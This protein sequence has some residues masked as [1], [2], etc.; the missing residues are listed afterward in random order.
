MPDQRLQVFVSS[1]PDELASERAAVRRVIDELRL[2][3]VMSASDSA[4]RVQL[5]DIFVGIYGESYGS[6]GAGKE[7]SQVEDEYVRA[8][9]KT[10]LIY[11]KDQ[12]ARRDARL[13][14]LVRR[15]ESDGRA[16]CKR[17]SDPTELA[18]ELESDLI[19]LL[20]E[21][22]AP[23]QVELPSGT[24]TMLF[25][26]IEGSTRLVRELG[27]RY[28]VVLADHHQVLREAWRTHA[29][30]EI[31]TDGDSF[32][33]VFRR[34]R[35]AVAAAVQAQR[36]LAAHRWPEGADLRVRMGMH[37]G[38]PA[39]GG[40]NYVGLGVH[41]AAR[42]AAAAHGGQVLLS[43][44][45]RYVLEKDELGGV[46]IV[47]LGPQ[48]LKDFEEPQ[49]LYQLGIDGLQA[50]FPALKTLAA[51]GENELP[52]AGQEVELA[53]AAREAIETEV[54][55]RTRRHLAIGLAAVGVAIAASIG[56]VLG[57]HGGGGTPHP[58]TTAAG[59]GQPGTAPSRGTLRHTA[60]R[61]IQR[62]TAR[63]PTTTRTVH[64]RTTPRRTALTIR[65]ERHNNGP[66][67]TWRLTCAPP[68]GTHPNPGLACAELSAHPRALLGRVEPCL[69][70]IGRTTPRAEVEG[71]FRGKVV[72]K[73]FAPSCGARFFK[74]LH[75]FFNG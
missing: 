34:A 29:G 21:H 66:T 74:P 19:V 39:L 13:G 54:G 40:D 30:Q 20:A 50:D 37:T 59:A 55:R 71:R 11:V 64:S 38:E 6:V 7:I 4:E 57:L 5:S 73:S 75:I 70:A 25:T 69:T 28:R 2:T 22:F 32:F 3:P 48:R 42:I 49:R 67:L 17:F 51:Q 35:N 1:T 62:R 14:A 9:G 31:G 72:S 45:T 58:R 16:S 53:E 52:F 46:S 63:S 44:A 68:G 47:D 8:E 56:I 12:V 26:D 60:P 27:D 10:A 41:R 36:A 15:I 61:P 43:E 18:H 24:V 33:V 23:K 65:Y